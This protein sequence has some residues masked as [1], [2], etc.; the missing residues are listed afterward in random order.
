IHRQVDEPLKF[1]LDPRGL[2][3]QGGIRDAQG[4]Q[5]LRRQQGFQP[6][7]LIPDLQQFKVFRAT[8]LRMVHR[9]TI[10][11]QQWIH[12]ASSSI[13]PKRVTRGSARWVGG[14]S[15]GNAVSITPSIPSITSH[16]TP[17]T[18][19]TTVGYATVS[20]WYSQTT[21]VGVCTTA[22]IRASYVATVAC[23]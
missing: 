19:L 11:R 13:V 15:G 21:A 3:R 4:L 18:S 12:T 9:D 23:A 7:E 5:F 16:R 14:P 8:D 17:A 20:Q 22:W 2:R 10:M 1:P 6:G